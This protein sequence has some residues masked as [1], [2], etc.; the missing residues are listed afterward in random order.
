MGIFDEF[1]PEKNAMITSDDMLNL[2][3]MAEAIIPERVSND[4]AA[5]LMRN[6]T[7]DERDFL[8]GEDK[9]HVV[10]ARNLFAEKV[11]MNRGAVG[12][13][14]QLVEAQERG[15]TEETERM[16]TLAKE[17]NEKI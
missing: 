11:A 5:V 13:L 17:L 8:I 2:I 1:D 15:D 14:Q 7:D 4:E 12:I 16:F 6:L 9:E 3:A 10:D